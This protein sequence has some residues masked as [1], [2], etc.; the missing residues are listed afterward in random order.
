MTLQ[1]ELW[2]RQDNAYPAKLVFTFVP[3]AGGDSAETITL[4]FTTWYTGLTI[5]L[6]QVSS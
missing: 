4:V 6:P 3:T 1:E 5:A 2:F